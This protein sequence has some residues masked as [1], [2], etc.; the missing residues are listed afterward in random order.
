M[1][2][3][4]LVR[5]WVE[6][7]SSPFRR[8]SVEVSLLVR[9]WV[10]MYWDRYSFCPKRRQPPCEAVSWNVLNCVL[11][12]TPFSQPPC[13]AVS[14]NAWHG[15]ENQ[16]VKKSASLWGCELK[17][18]GQVYQKHRTYVSLLVRLWV[19]IPTPRTYHVTCSSSASLWGCELKCLIPFCYKPVKIV[20]LLVRLWVEMVRFPV[21]QAA[22]TC[23]PPCEAV[24]WN[25]LHAFVKNWRQQS[26]SLWGCELKSQTL[27]LSTVR[28]GCQPP[29]EAVS[30]NR[31]ICYS[32][33]VGLMSASLW[34]CEL[35]YIEALTRKSKAGSASLWGCELK[36]SNEFRWFCFDRQPPCEAVS[37]NASWRKY[38][39]IVSCQPPC[40][41]VSW[42]TSPVISSIH[43]LRSASLWGCELKYERRKQKEWKT[44]SASLWGCELKSLY[45][46]YNWI[47]N[48]SAS[49]WG[50][51][52]KYF[53]L[54]K[55]VIT[56]SQPPCEAVSW[57]ILNHPCRGRALRVS[58]LVRLWVEI[59]SVLLYVYKVNVSLLVRLWV[60]MFPN[61]T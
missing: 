29:C 26:A 47:I 38:G 8:I 9:L 14:W 20:S 2:V 13:E 40:E 21:W 57:N 7:N 33:S 1:D 43:W 39:E 15:T 59:L 11:L 52:L 18:G 45:Q 58:L 36:W 16:L 24:S 17:Y 60:E 19:E 34:G 49:L 22:P 5:L 12:T 56:F 27:E 35:K 53:K 25:T 50:C 44:W 28:S 48:P 61:T 3:S 42:N 41:A 4:L 6:M 31:C 54:R 32:P 23:Q 10:E 30:W 46:M 51:E 55:Q 37:W